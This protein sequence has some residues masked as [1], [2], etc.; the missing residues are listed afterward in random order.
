MKLALKLIRSDGG[1]QPRTHTDAD[2]IEQY[3][4]DMLRGDAFPP[5]EIFLDAEGNH[6]LADGFHRFMAAHELGIAEIEANITNGTLRDARMHAFTKANTTHGKRRT[7]QD[8]RRAAEFLLKD[9]HWKTLPDGAIADACRTNQRYIKALRAELGVAA[10]SVRRDGRKIN[11]NQN[12]ARNARFEKKKA[13][14]VIQQ[15]EIEKRRLRQRKKT[16]EMLAE[17]EELRL[18][19]IMKDLPKMKGEHLARLRIAIDDQIAQMAFGE[20]HPT[21]ASA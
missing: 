7:S 6:W 5:V 9:K 16:P 17:Q 4:E 18:Q 3:K 1:T 20:S 15:A 10:A 2:T 14:Q 13:I 11:P 8:L 21:S 19:V 12:K